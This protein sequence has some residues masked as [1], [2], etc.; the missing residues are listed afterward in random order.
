MTLVATTTQ[1]AREFLA[2]QTPPLAK[3]GARGRF[4]KEGVAALDAAR[5]SGVVF[6]DDVKVVKA[7][8]AVETVKVKA[9]A[10]PA[11]AV[12][13]PAP[14]AAP[15]SLNAAEVRAWAKG[16]GLPVGER[17]RI[18]PDVIAAFVKAKGGKV[19]LAKPVPSP[20]DVAKRIRPQRVAYGRVPR[21]V[22][23]GDHITEPILAIESCGKCRK[24][25]P[26][27]PCDGGPRLPKWAGHAET[28][29]DKR[30]A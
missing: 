24:A 20:A 26:F 21:P 15:A 19:S 29:F 4:G 8:K 6:A 18:K 9:P 22:G 28:V 11:Q 10:V 17:G 5:K 30:L 25:V 12:A 7:P 16:K 27:C 3:A 13:S 2:A 1:T 14:A 23:E